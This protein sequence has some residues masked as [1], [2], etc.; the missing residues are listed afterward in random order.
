MRTL[1]TSM[2]S[3]TCADIANEYR[4]TVNDEYVSPRLQ[5]TIRASHNLIPRRRETT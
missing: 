3:R 1:C 4:R 2:E 5:A